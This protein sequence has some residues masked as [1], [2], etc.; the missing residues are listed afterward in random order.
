MT[1]EHWRSH[2]GLRRA[3][4]KGEPL[5]DVFLVSRRDL[6]W[7]LDNQLTLP[8][9]TLLDE[10]GVDFGD[11]YSRDAAH[12]VQL[13]QPAAVH[14]V[15]RRAPGRLLQRRPRR[16]RRAWR[17]AGSTCRATRRRWNWDQ[18]VAA[19]KFAARPSKG[20]KGVVGRA[21]AARHRA[22]RVLRRRRPVRRR[23]R[24]DLAGVHRRGH[25]GRPADGAAAVPRPEGDADRG[26][27][28][29]PFRAD[30]VRAGQARH[31]H[32]QPGARPA[33]AER[34]RPRLGR[35][36][37]PVDRGGATTG[38][39]T[40]LC[41]SQDRREPR[42]LGRLHGLRHQHRRGHRGRPSR[43]PPAGQPGG[44]VL[45]RLPPARR[46]PALGAR[47]STSRWAGW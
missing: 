38:E 46:G 9:D 35:D 11:V 4:E 34:A 17:P 36:R 21:D 25:P 10:R 31:D 42:D 37:D 2:A 3:V 29:R 28:G 26:G 32:R 44:R 5:P 45:R 6:R 16:L 24:P 13:R 19:A 14:A 20:T 41:I 40:A 22:V 15:R 27:A 33:A 23:Q 1:V 30:V 8:V 39:I 43:L 47:S 7:Y 12:G 18:F